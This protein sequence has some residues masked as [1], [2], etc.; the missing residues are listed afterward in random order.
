MLLRQLFIL[1]QQKNKRNILGKI[2]LAGDCKNI[3]NLKDLEEQVSDYVTAMKQQNGEE[4]STT[5]I[6]NAMHAI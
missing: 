6:I 4:Y 3:T 5:S 2:G 1:N